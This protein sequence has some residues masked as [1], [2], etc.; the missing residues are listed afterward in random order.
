MR[1]ISK[2]VKSFVS[3][4]KAPDAP[5]NAVR[6]SDMNRPEQASASAGASAAVS[7]PDG[8]ASATVSGPTPPP[9]PPPG[10]QPNQQ[11]N[12]PGWLPNQQGNDAGTGSQYW[13]DQSGQWHYWHQAEKI[14]TGYH[15][16][17]ILLAALYQSGLHKELAAELQRLVT[18][19]PLASGVA[20]LCQA[21]HQEGAEAVYRQGF[22]ARRF[23]L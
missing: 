16:K 18:Y 19:R 14:K 12:D 9:G 17:L 7:G 5:W 2:A 8:G 21:V 6:Y 23:Q 11:H 20:S 1:P 22:I 13:M 15:N 4:S 3:H 10:W